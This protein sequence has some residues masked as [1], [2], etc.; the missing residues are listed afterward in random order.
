MTK[1]A[2]TC[3]KATG[4]LE[5]GVTVCLRWTA[6][7][8]P[9]ILAT[10]HLSNDYELHIQAYQYSYVPKTFELESRWSTDKAKTQYTNHN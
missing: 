5:T 8:Q 4:E 2:K 10:I 1:T 9:Y 7:M 6:H 3:G